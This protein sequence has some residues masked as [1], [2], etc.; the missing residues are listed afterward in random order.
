MAEILIKT[1][2]ITDKYSI[3]NNAFKLDEIKNPE[4]DNKGEPKDEIN[5]EIGDTKQT[6]FY[7]QIKLQRWTNE[8]NFSVRL[9]DTEY[10]KAQITTDKDKIIWDKDNIKIDFY[11]FQEGEGG[12]KMVWYLKSKPLTNK[13]EF[14]IQSKGLDF[15]YQPELTPEEIAKGAVRPPEVEGGYAIYHQTKGVMNDINGKDYKTGQAFFI[16]KSR[17]TDAEG[18]QEWAILNIDIEK[19]S[20]TEEIPQDFLNKAVYPIRGNTNWGYETIGGTTESGDFG[21]EVFGSVFT[22]PADMGTVQSISIYA[23]TG[24]FSSGLKGLLILD[25]SLNIITNGIT[26]AMNPVASAWNVATYGT[27]PSP[28]P[29]TA[30]II[31]EI[32]NAGMYWRYNAGD[33]NQGVNDTSNNYTSPANLVSVTRTTNKYS[34]YATY[35]PSG[36]GVVAPP[37]LNLMGVGK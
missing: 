1:K 26:A 12:Y 14:T 24:D 10:E 27:E 13:I 32:T 16:Y 8:T 11:D 28:T 31:G 17:L 35:T 29:S 33:T 25:S 20:F 18:K 6:E 2:E 9:K 19:G 3:V 34:I 4:L 7:P 15:F 37:T 30:Y 5:V 36:E 22:A 23:G 21:N